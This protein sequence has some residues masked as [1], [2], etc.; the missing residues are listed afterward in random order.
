MA[1]FK[2]CGRCG[3][4]VLPPYILNL[5]TTVGICQCSLPHYRKNKVEQQKRKVMD[6]HKDQQMKRICKS[7]CLV[8]DLAGYDLNEFLQWVNFR[9]FCQL[10]QDINNDP[11]LKD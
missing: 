7:L 4:T 8:C 11:M 5:R 2:L 9:A 10:D 6:E 3:D 1:E